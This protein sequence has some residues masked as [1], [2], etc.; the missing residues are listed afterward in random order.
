MLLKSLDSGRFLKD[1]RQKSDAF[2]SSMEAHFPRTWQSILEQYPVERQPSCETLR[3]A[4][5]RLDT[6]TMCLRQSWNNISQGAHVTFTGHSLFSGPTMT[7]MCFPQ[8]RQR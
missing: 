2:Q 4:R 8:K 7:D 1:I 3:K 6:T 5:F